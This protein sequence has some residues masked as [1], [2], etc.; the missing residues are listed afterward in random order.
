M[1]IT[2]FLA[3]CNK[4]TKIDSTKNYYGWLG[5]CVDTAYE[6]NFER[7]SSIVYSRLR[8]TQNS[9]LKEKYSIAYGTIEI[10]AN[11][12]YIV[13]FPNTAPKQIEQDRETNRIYGSSKDYGNVYFSLC[14][15]ESITL[16]RNTI[17][18]EHTL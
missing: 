17:A 9:V 3:S 5:N 15:E 13:I 18:N 12:S 16:V 8:F 14:G 7:R 6:F 2:V 4:E 10:D 1:L 11:G